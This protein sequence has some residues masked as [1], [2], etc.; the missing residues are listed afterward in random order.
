MELQGKI[1]RTSRN[2]A[3][4][5]LHGFRD[6]FVGIF[7]VGRTRN[8]G[9]KRLKGISISF[10]RSLP[11]SHRKHF[12][13][14]DKCKHATVI[15]LGIIIRLCH[16]KN[17]PLSCLLLENAPFQLLNHPSRSLRSDWDRTSMEHRDLSSWILNYGDSWRSC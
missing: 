12:L 14:S 5:R 7:Y 2:F 17:Q 13:L 9:E 11:A 15:F 1:C 16:L 3:F 4:I 10:H 6:V 8:A